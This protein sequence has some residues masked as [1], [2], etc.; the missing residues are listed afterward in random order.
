MMAT[1]SQRDRMT[2]VAAALLLVVG[3][4][5]EL[6]GLGQTRRLH[7]QHFAAE[8]V[9]VAIQRC[10]LVREPRQ[11]DFDFLYDG[12]SG[13]TFEWGYTYELDVEESDVRN[14]PQ[15]GSSISRALQRVVSRTRVP[16]GTSFDL[17]ITGGSE[18]VVELSANRYRFLGDAEFRCPE[19]LACAELRQ[20]ISASKRIHF[21]FTHPHDPAEPLVVA[22]WAE[23]FRPNVVFVCDP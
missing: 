13:F 22:D 19:N 21:R 5:C 2:L 9:G 8:C 20:A 10:L 12:I 4:G 17:V 23:C 7:V 1:G 3:S 14:P 11:T 6:L 15:D 16:A 18:R